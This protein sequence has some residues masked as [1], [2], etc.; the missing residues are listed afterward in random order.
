MKNLFGAAAKCITCIAG[1]TA[2]AGGLLLARDIVNPALNIAAEITAMCTPLALTGYVMS[3]LPSGAR[4]TAVA[5]LAGFTAFTTVICGEL[6]REDVA[7]HKYDQPAPM[8]MTMG[9][10]NLPGPH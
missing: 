2:L 1:G 8:S 4:S 10:P 6:R 7:A 5:A 9:W 3:K